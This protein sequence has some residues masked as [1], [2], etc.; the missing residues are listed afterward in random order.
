MT[1]KQTKLTRS[2]AK[3]LPN[4]DNLNLSA[5]R[6]W[7]INTELRCIADGF[8]EFASYCEA[9]SYALKLRREGKIDLALKF[10]SACEVQYQ[11]IPLW[12]KW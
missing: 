6:L 9:K 11:R 7:E 2:A 10:E 5:E 12:A 3:I 1:T 4:I 8:R